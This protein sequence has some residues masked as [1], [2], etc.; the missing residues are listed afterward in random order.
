MELVC[1][2]VD[3]NDGQVGPERFWVSRGCVG[4]P[5]GYSPPKKRGRRRIYKRMT[6]TQAKLFKKLV[7]AGVSATE[8]RT[9]AMKVL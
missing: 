3:N 6:V 8:A 5:K 7:N 1:S 2:V 4:R 9:E